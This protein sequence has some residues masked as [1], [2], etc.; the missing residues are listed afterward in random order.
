MGW[1]WRQTQLESSIGKFQAPSSKL[2]RSSKTK[3]PST[4]LQDPKK[5]QAPTSNPP[6]MET[7][8]LG[9]GPWSFSGAWMLDLGAYLQRRLSSIF[10]FYHPNPSAILYP[11]GPYGS[12]ADRGC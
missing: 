9:F 7:R 8:L 1:A 12:G 6:S 5:L 11:N 4:K 2:Q 3:T 10:A